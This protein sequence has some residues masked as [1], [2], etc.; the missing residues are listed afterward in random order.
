MDSFIFYGDYKK[1][2][3]KDNLSQIIDSDPEILE[4]L[5][6]SA[7]TEMKG[8]LD[9]KYDTSI[10]L[11]SI[12]KWDKTKAYNAGQNVYIDALPYSATSLYAIG[13][14]VL[15][16]GLIYKCNTAITIV[17]VFNITHWTLTGKVH[18][19]FNSIL[20]APIFDIN[21]IYNIGDTVLYL[22][23]IYTCKIATSVLSHYDKI[24]IGNAA[25]N[26]IVNYYPTDFS[27]GLKY[28][29]TGEL[30]NVPA[31]TDILNATYWQQ[32]DTRDQK[33]IQVAVDI[34]LY[35]AHC[36]I[37]PMNVPTLRVNRYMG[38]VSSRQTG[39]Q[40]ITFPATSALGWLQECQN[41]DG[42]TPNLPLLPKVADTQQG[43]I[44]FSGRQ[45]Q[46]NYW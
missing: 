45:K 9:C 31:S 25:V 40:R 17:E 16:N 44:R 46:Q 5:Q 42:I 10:A 30:Y 3:Q 12:S 2:I 39:G 35:N 41:A 36:R 21:G 1:I 23:K 24:Q 19:V 4:Q 22:N 43:E 33:L 8:Y 26:P 6:S 34:V 13:T 27:R 38:D 14:L 11:Q 37:S 20:P 18:T 7:I 32:G 15:Q 28:W 29:G